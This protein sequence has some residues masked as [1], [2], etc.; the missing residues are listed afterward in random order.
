MQLKEKKLIFFFLIISL[1]SI[2]LIANRYEK[3]IAT[4]DLFLQDINKKNYSANKIKRMISK[5]PDYVGDSII[6]F[7]DG[8]MISSNIKFQGT[9]ENVINSPENMNMVYADMRTSQMPKAYCIYKLASYYY[10]S[11][12]KDEFNQSVKPK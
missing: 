5:L 10:K 12:Y 2:Y 4:K 1:S 6:I 7:E 11:Q 8:E 3:L 9:I